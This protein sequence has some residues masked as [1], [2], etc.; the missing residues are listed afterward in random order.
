MSGD[1]ADAIRVC[2]GVLT[3]WAQELGARVTANADRARH[4]G[5][6]DPIGQ[7]FEDGE[8]LIAIAHVIEG[9]RR[10]R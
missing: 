5:T 8:D 6:T 9:L 2:L 10:R 4:G 3:E 1:R 7:T